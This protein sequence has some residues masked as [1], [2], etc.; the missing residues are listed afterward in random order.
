[1]KTEFLD[2]IPLWLFFLTTIA[3]ILL[4]VE[5][6]YLMGN[7]RRKRSEQEKEAPVG[8]MVGAALGLLAFM[9]AFTFGMATSRFDASR[10]VLLDEANAIGT[11]YLRAGLFAEPYRSEIRKLLREYVNVRL[12]GV[13]LNKYEEAVRKSEDLHAHLWAQAT[14]LV[15]TDPNS[16][17]VG[18]FIQSLNDTI[19]LHAK[20]V[21]VGLGRRIPVTIWIVLFIMTALS[22]AAMGYHA[23]LSGTRRSLAILPIALSFALVIL[24]I[25]DLDRP[26]KGLIGVSQ[27]AMIDL[28]KSMNTMPP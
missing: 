20:R 22:L 15:E 27:Q 18:L 16:F 11:T 6:G 28:Q 5:A 14:S 23:G 7:Y 26:G 24:L 12:E 10:Q 13:N 17:I 21:T 2:I 25:V 4:S 9:L 8:A 3:V 1:M 19:D